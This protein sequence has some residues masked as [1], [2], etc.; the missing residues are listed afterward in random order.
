MTRT[1][2]KRAPKGSIDS[3]LLIRFPK[4]V[5]KRLDVAAKKEGLSVAEWV[6]QA[7]V[8]LLPHE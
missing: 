6:R 5:R 2:P 1:P 4:D 3:A 7:I 8:A